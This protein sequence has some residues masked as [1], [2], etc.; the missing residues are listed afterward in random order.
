MKKPTKK[1]VKKWTLQILDPQ[2]NVTYQE[3]AEVSETKA[4]TLARKAEK[5]RL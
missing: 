4:K 1:T 2:G 3:T 5:K